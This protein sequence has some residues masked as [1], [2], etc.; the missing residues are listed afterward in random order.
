MEVAWLAGLRSRRS[1]CPTRPGRKPIDIRTTTKLKDCWI[2]S[3]KC[4]TLLKPST[5]KKENLTN[6]HQ[7]SLWKDKIVCIIKTKY[8]IV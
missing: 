5:N 2:K 4:S 7:L 6:L 1:R 8:R 3:F